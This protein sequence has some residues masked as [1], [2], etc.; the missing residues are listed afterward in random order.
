M[1]VNKRQL[2]KALK[3]LKKYCGEQEMC[4]KCQFGFSNMFCNA[5][6]NCPEEWN[7]D[8]IMDYS[9]VEYADAWE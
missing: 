3:T 5:S 7:I 4:S 8:R 6:T 2:R 1:K 9:D